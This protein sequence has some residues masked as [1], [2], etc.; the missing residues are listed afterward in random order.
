VPKS[1]TDG[2]RYG[3]DMTSIEL[4]GIWCDQIRSG[5]ITDLEATFACTEAIIP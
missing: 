5:A 2:W 1:E 4:T 3:P